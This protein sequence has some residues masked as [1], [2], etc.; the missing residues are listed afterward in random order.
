MIV[1]SYPADR[2]RYRSRKSTLRKPALFQIARRSASPA[3]ILFAAAPIEAMESLLKAL[4]M[5][6]ILSRLGFPQADRHCLSARNSRSGGGSHAIFGMV[7]KGSE[8]L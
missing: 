6:V 2:N 5:L 7:E 8:C 1:P 3:E 4:L